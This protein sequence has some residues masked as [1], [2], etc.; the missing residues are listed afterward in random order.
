MRCI[1]LTKFLDNQEPGVLL[2]KMCLLFLQKVFALH[3]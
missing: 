3:I 2:T 1:K